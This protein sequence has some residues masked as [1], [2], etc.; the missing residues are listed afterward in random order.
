VPFVQVNAYAIFIAGEAAA[1]SLKQEMPVGHARAYQIPTLC[2]DSGGANCVSRSCRY[3]SQHHRITTHFQ[4]H[5]RAQLT[6]RILSLCSIHHVA[7]CALR[8]HTLRWSSDAD[9]GD[10]GGEDDKPA[11]M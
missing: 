6:E 1:E 8:K 4:R 11:R 10:D 2:V 5:F 9:D 7:L 3:C